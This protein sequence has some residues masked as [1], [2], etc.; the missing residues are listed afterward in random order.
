[1]LTR[2]QMHTVFTLNTLRHSCYTHSTQFLSRKKKKR[3]KKIAS[4]S[5]FHSYDSWMRV[6][7]SRAFTLNSESHSST[8]LRSEP[9]IFL[10]D[11]PPLWLPGGQTEAEEGGGYSNGKRE[12]KTQEEN[13]DS[14]VNFIYKEPFITHNLKVLTK[15]DN[16]KK[17]CSLQCLKAINNTTKLPKDFKYRTGKCMYST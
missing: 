4:R 15:E 3:E 8:T 5:R 2:W 9:S 7:Q 6:A 17:I 13:E 16:I 14:N 1:M 12:R 11:T 10:R